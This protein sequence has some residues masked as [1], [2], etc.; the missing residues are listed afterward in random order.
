MKYYKVVRKRESNYCSCRLGCD[1]KWAVEYKVG[2]FVSPKI[3]KV[4]IFDSLANAQAFRSGQNELIFE[5][6]AEGVSKEGVFV[7]T[8]SGFNGVNWVDMWEEFR[9]TKISFIDND[10]AFPDGTLFADSVKL[11]VEKTIKPREINQY[12]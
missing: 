8:I 12:R 1:P 4:F 10:K 5:V 3:G 2:E 6:E 11:I 9:L 7:D